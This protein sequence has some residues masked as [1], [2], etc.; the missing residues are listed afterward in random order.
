M[1]DTLRDLR[2]VAW[3]NRATP[4]RLPYDVD[5]RPFLA[6]GETVSGVT[7]AVVPPDALTVS[8]PVV[9]QGVARVFIEGGIAGVNYGL[10]FVAAT[11][12]GARIAQRR[13]LYVE[14]PLAS[15]PPP[16]PPPVDWT[17]LLVA[18][19]QTVA[20]RDEAVPAASQAVAARNDAVP[21][22]AAAAADRA[23]AAASRWRQG[24]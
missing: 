13:S 18:R 5:F 2:P 22:A 8:A 21:A 7:V 15:D 20:A 23:P 16:V 17:A 14:M 12:A 6:G 9:T 1:S 10:E 3:P 4:E 24:Q 11:S 19:D